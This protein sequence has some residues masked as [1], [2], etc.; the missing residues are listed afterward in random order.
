MSLSRKE[1]INSEL[2]NKE[3]LLRL[4]DT[5]D[6]L[7]IF[8][9]GACEAEDSVRY[10]R[11]F[12]NALV[13]AFEPLV[14]NFEK[15]KQTVNEHAVKDISLFNIALGDHSG[16]AEF[17]V[18][19]GNPPTEKNSEEWDYGNKSSSLLQPDKVKEVFPWIN[20]DEK[21]KVEVRTMLEFCKEQ[22]ISD[23]D[24]I[25]MD[26]QGAELKVLK[27]AGKLVSNVKVIWLEVENLT[28]YKN[29]PLKKDIID[30]FSTNGFR[31]LKDTVNNVAG[32]MLF[33][34]SKYFPEEEANLGIIGRYN[35]K[36]RYKYFNEAYYRNDCYSQHGEDL[37]INSCLRDL[38]IHKPSYIDV[39]AHHPF[40]L[41]NTYF[42]YLKGCKGINVEP[43]P[44]LFGLFEKQRPD[45][46]NV[47]VGVFKERS[48]M[49][50]Y[51]MHPNT[52]STFSASEMENYKKIGHE[53]RETIQVD[54]ETINDIIGKYNDGIFPDFLS[55]DIEGIDLEVLKTMN[56][57]YNYPKVICVE[58]TMYDGSLTDQKKNKP[59]IDL[60]LNKGYAIYADTF[61]N[62]IFYRS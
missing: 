6:K 4:F 42:F 29:Q 35:K 14:T 18:S 21:I 61:I 49:P 62:T 12:T 3:E 41:N 17:Y 15:C 39:G 34:N 2:P 30:F 32:D 54:V 38:G 28:L 24:I 43:D 50:F 37:I 13:Y 19:S 56:Y 16:T 11:L 60:L 47:N 8:D 26:V 48:K 7:T 59:I 46:I 25:H 5:K 36:I 51:V 33:V 55:L 45:D 58:T 22:K 1:F 53:L 57:E 27:G 52:L 40:R 9:I 23:I 44:H 31:A 10:K 20:F